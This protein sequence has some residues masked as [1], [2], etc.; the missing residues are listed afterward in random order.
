MILGAMIITKRANNNI[1]KNGQISRMI[2]PKGIPVTALITNSRTPYG[3][4]MRPIIEFT[5]T[6][7][8]K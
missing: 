4:V 8:P 2:S 3:G 7:I 6:K 5:T 1:P